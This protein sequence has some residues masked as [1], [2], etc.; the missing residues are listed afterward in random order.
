MEVTVRFT[1]KIFWQ[2]YSG[3]ISSEVA[4]QE[5][6]PL[7]SHRLASSSDSYNWYS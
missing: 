2:K 6:M 4:S 7:H 5:I 3:E 1:H